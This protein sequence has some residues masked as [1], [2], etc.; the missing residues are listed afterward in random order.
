MLTQVENEVHA[1]TGT[2]SIT[3][4]FSP[5]GKLLNASDLAAKQG[6]IVIYV[7]RSLAITIDATRGISRT[8][9]RR[10][11]GLPMKV[12]Y[13]T[14]A[15]GKQQHGECELNGGGE[16]LHLRAA[17]G[18]IH[19]IYADTLMKQQSL[20]MEQQLHLQTKQFQEQMKQMTELAQTSEITQYTE[21][22]RAADSADDAA[23][24]E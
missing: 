3:A 20:A 12:N 24:G 2:G 5:S 4:W 8:P 18:N 17:A 16:V 15:A 23:A 19:L 10:G 6:D 21:Q 9:H 1:S 22:T 13:V 14:N 11:S 7:P